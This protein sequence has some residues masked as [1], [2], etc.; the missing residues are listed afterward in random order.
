MLLVESLDN[1][2]RSIAQS[3]NVNP[4][5][6]TEIEGKYPNDKSRVTFEIL[7]HWRDQAKERADTITLAGEM[8]AALTKLHLTI[9]ADG[10]KHS[11]QFSEVTYLLTIDIIYHE[12]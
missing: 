4:R 8:R 6:V 11:T 2:H 7:A 10:I 5:F 9:V 3:L 1:T 12:T